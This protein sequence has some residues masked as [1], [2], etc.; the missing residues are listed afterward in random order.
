MRNH[1]IRVAVVVLFAF[2]WILPGNAQSQGDPQAGPRPLRVMTY[3]IHH[4][5][6]NVPCT[7]PPVTRPPAPDC[8]LDLDAIADVIRAQDPDVV[9]LQEV[10]R[11]WARSAYV[12]QPAYLSSELKMFSCYAAN[13][14]HQPDSHSNVPHQY[15]T[16]ILSR[17]PILDCAN[18]YLPRTVTTNEQRGLLQALINVRGVPLR[19]NNTHLHTTAADRVV[20]VQAITNL[21][22][23]PSEPTVLVGDLNARPT[24]ASL[25]PLYGILLDSWILAGSGAG[26]TYPAETDRLPDR[27]IDYIFASE[28]VTVS[29]VD[30]A[31]GS[32]TTLASDHY[33]VVA[34]IALPGL[35]VGIGPQ[36]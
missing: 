5:T 11:F 33:P 24:E 19:F 1:V 10:D 28:G 27:R 15:G 7:P 3:N 29:Q 36:H 35:A 18:T 9:G 30:V 14:D 21:I 12:D 8:G 26:F 16:L 13:L 2:W 32:L 6:G 25:Q 34:E 17:F 23:T 4:G 31:L 22:G 20:Q